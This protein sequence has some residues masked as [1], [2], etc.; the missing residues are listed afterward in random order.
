MNKMKITIIVL[1]VIFILL[2]TYFY[3]NLNYIKKPLVATWK[4]GFEEK[5]RKL[6]DGT[7]LNYGEGPDNG[8]TPLL[9]IH[10]QG[11][12]WQDYA[13]NLPELAKH[14]HV[15]AIDCHGHGKSD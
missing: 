6:K 10:G 5:Q 13:K 3:T 4:A 8:K 14:Y 2:I 11:M 1:L 15:Y 12:N 9:L 7:I